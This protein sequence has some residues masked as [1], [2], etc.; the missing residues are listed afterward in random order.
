MFSTTR[1]YTWAVHC[2]QAVPAC[3]AESAGYC[4]GAAFRPTPQTRN[5]F[6]EVTQWQCMELSGLRQR[7][8]RY[9]TP[10]NGNG[11]GKRRSRAAVARAFRAP[12]PRIG[13]G[14]G[15][16]GGRFRIANSNAATGPGGGGGPARRAGAHSRFGFRRPTNARRARV[17]RCMLSP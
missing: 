10:P 9:S 5:R 4:N 15:R 1:V 12:P 6:E 17:G 14:F 3:A 13:L 2:A 16:R 7:V 8:P 11:T